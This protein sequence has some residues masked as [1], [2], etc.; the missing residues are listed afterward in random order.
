MLTKEEMPACPVAT[1]VALIGS[2]WKLLILRNL[3][4][5][6]WRFNELKKDL[7]GVSQKVLTDSLR[8]L[9]EDGIV[10]RTVYPEV[11]PRVE[12]ALS[13]LGESMRPIIDVMRR[14][15]L[16]YQTRCNDVVL[17][18]FFRRKLDNFLF[19]GRRKKPAGP[20]AFSACSRLLICR[21]IQRGDDT[22][23]WDEQEAAFQGSDR[24]FLL[25]LYQEFSRLM[26]YTAQKYLADPHSQEEVVQESLKKL[27]EKVA[28]LRRLKRPALA[29][30][31][32]ATVRNTA[33]DLLKVQGRERERVVGLEDLTQGETP[34]TDSLDETVFCREEVQR[35]REIW[36]QLDGE[37]R[38]LLERKYILGYENEELGRMLGCRTDSV[39]MKLTRARRKVLRLMGKEAE[40]REKS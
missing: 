21:S 13:D 14:W 37:T 40:K 23:P 12:Y 35:L 26:F 20:V 31:V 24:E 30:Y 5:R 11:P 16:E 25:W 8:S 34:R 32:R 38:M 15:G 10:T 33:I 39:R 27:I 22:M 3:M 18:N 17:L 28:V 2:K 19:S 29:G 36:P 7:N 4:A 1:T 6:P 9:E